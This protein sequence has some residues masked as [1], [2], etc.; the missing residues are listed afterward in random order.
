M[1]CHTDALTEVKDSSVE[2][3]TVEATEDRTGKKALAG[4]VIGT[5]NNNTTLTNVTASGNTVKNYGAVGYSEMIGRVVSGKL[6]IDGQTVVSN[7]AVTIDGVVT[8][9]PQLAK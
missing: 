4:A 9:V 1:V 5:V 3:I 8:N 2:N 6:T 7:A